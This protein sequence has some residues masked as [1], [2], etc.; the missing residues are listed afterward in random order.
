MRKLIQF[1]ITHGS[2]FA[3]LCYAAICLILLF[4]F[5]PYQ[6]SVYFSSAA[7][8]SGSVYAL[9][10]TVTGYFGLQKAN[11]E[12]LAQNGKLQSEL[13]VLRNTLALREAEDTLSRWVVPAVYPARVIVAKIVNNSVANKNNYITIDK[14]RSDGVVPEMGIVDQNGVVGVIST[15]S[16]GYAVALSLLNPNLRISCKV[17]GSENIGSLIWTGEDTRHAILEE[18]TTN[19][20]VNVG[21]TIVTSGF[22]SAFPEGLTVGY[23]VDAKKKREKFFSVK[24]R[25]A[26]DF[27]TLNFVQVVDNRRPL[28]QKQI[29][30]EAHRYE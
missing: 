23:V 12:L 5:N 24:V 13:A 16:S 25:L 3:Y 30:E 20:V 18:L 21:D 22:S 28:E 11:R 2:L 27:S 8:I 6:Q 26:A 15:S 1:F 4:T 9:S 10:G 7:R 29:E 19:A 17:Q 14:G